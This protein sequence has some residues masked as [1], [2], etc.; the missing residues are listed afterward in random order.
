MQLLGK[1]HINK[2]KKRHAAARKSLDRWMQLMEAAETKKPEDFRKVFGNS[3]V[4]SNARTPIPCGIV[5][6][7]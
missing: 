7:R 5:N 6:C 2:F 4:Q 3:F 1:Q